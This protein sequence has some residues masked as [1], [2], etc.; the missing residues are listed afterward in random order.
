MICFYCPKIKNLLLLLLFSLFSLTINA[1]KNAK[2]WEALFDNNRKEA[3]RLVNNLNIDEDIE[4]LILKKVVQMENGLMKSDPNFLSRVVKYENYE[5]YLFSNWFLTYFFNDYINEGFSLMTYKMPLLLNASD[6]KNSTVKNGLYYLQAV[7]NRHQRNW[8]E[9]TNL[10]N[11]VNAIRDWEFCGVFENL[12]SSGI[13]M[14]YLPEEKVLKNYV[15]DAQSKGDAQWYK[16]TNKAEVYNFFSNHLEFGSGVHYAQTFINSKVNQRVRLR[17]GK[18]GLMRTWL[19]DVLILESDE[20]HMTELD[21][22]TLEVNLHKGVNRVLIKLATGGSVPYFILRLENLEG[23]LLNNYQVS[24][25]NKKYI[26]RGV[27]DVNAKLIPH[28]IET[29]FINKLQDSNSDHNLTKFCLFLTYY[30]NGRVNE[31]ISVLDDWVKQN[32]K[33]SFLKSCLIY[34]YKAKGDQSSLKKLQNNLKREDNDYYLSSILEFENFKELMKL[35]IETYNS[36]FEKI[37]KATDYSYIKT[38]SDLMILLRQQKRVEVRKKLD[39]LLKDKML[40]SKTKPTFFELYATFFNDDNETINKLEKYNQT[41]FNSEAVKYLAYYYKKQNRI[42]DVVNLYLDVLKKFNDDNNFHLNLIQLLHDTG[43]F[44]RSLPYIENALK[45]YPNSYLFTKLKGDAYVQVN[46]K[47][48]AIALYEKALNRSPSDKKLRNKINDLK[49]NKNLLADFD[50]KAPYEYINKNRNVI[51]KN[52]YGLNTLLNQTNI[53][54]FKRG[55]GEYRTTFIYE[56]TS[57]N[58]IGIFKEYDLGLSGDYLIS[59]SEIIKSNGETVPADRNGSKLVFEDLVIGDVIYISYQAFYSKS[60]RFYKDYIF[61][62]SFNDYHPS[63]NNIYRFLTLDKKVNNIVKNGKVNYTKSKKGDYY[64]HEWSLKNSSG[65]LVTE[66]YMPN[67]NDIVTRLHVSSINSWNDIAVW[68]SDVVRKQL[69][70]DKTVKESFKEIFPKGYKQLSEKERAKLI[71]YYI[72]DNFNYSYVS[73]RQGGYV[74]QKPSKTIKTK[75]GDCKDFSS[76]F[77]ALSKLADLD[78]RL[79]LILTADYAK[80]EMI[81]P[82][83]D[84]NHCIVKVKLDGKDQFLELTDKNLPF[85]SIPMSLRGATALEIPYDTSTELTSKLFKL[86][87]VAR[88]KSKFVSNTELNLNSKNSEIKLTTIVSG[89]LASYYIDLFKNKKGKILTD[90]VQEEISNRCSEAI[91]LLNLEEV[92]LEKDKG[93]IKYVTNLSAD[94]KTNKIGDLFTFNI[95]YF[96]NPYNESIVQLSERN[97]P[98]DYRKYENTDVYN[99]SI[100]INLKNNEEF[101]DLPKDLESRFKNHEFS[102]NYKLVGPNKLQVG[103]KANVSSKLIEVKEYIEFKAHVT[104]VLD[105]RSHLVSYKVISNVD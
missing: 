103:I 85:R 59:K 79:V 67:F 92:D 8:K 30:R 87:D 28:S 40:P 43:Q 83:T 96:L 25:D 81:L 38:V 9:Y 68:Y 91:K 61:N 65:I 62:H 39:E 7:T 10:M 70:V 95:P 37:R 18:S 98:I 16:S 4:N 34:C 5:N 46:R 73:F 55:G 72:T 100:T 15:F 104:K 50:L 56:I 41:E 82:S 3:L 27:E 12:N 45:N 77:L 69:K 84:F 32:P 24:F 66:D 6:I 33:S 99:E 94:I 52:N 75:L 53:L 102:I 93:Q 54:N 97:Y 23:K 22:Y 90:E 1:Q 88:Q 14:P 105:S 71:Y 35:D 63:V 58:G 36:K 19:N 2:I 11:K 86:V 60:G 44:K 26:K 78:T 17:I 48:E 21:A 42:E 13:D 57:Q 29:F 49:K 80:N 101:V 31:A 64:V 89:H 74:P 47:T 76:L 20:S 51:K